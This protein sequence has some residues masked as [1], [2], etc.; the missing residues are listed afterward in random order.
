MT[1]ESERCCKGRNVSPYLVTI[2]SQHSRTLLD[3]P[4]YRC[5]HAIGEALKWS[6]LIRVEYGDQH[7]Y[8]SIDITYATSSHSAELQTLLV[9]S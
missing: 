3:D 1:Y 2:V 9:K 6:S 7:I 5:E 8:E 4:D